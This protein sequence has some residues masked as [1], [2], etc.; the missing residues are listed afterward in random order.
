LI[1]RDNFLILASPPD[2]KMSIV[3]ANVSIGGISWVS[4]AI[5][6]GKSKDRN[7]RI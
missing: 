2:D 3:V 6:I 1:G 5:P 7:L 4:S